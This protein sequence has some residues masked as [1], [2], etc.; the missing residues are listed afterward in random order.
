MKKIIALAAAVLL[1]LSVFSSMVPSSYAVDFTDGDYQYTVTD[2]EASITKYTGTALDLTVPSTLGGYPVVDIGGFSDAPCTRITIPDSVRTLGS[3]AFGPALEYLD[4]G[5][6]VTL[7]ETQCCMHCRNLREVVFSS[8]LVT[9]ESMAFSGVPLESVSFPASLETIGDSAFIE[10][11]D[12]TSVSFSEGLKSIGEGAFWLCSF[13][14]L[15]FPSTLE[16]IGE[17][18]FCFNDLLT[19]INFAGE[20]PICGEL[21]FSTVDGAR[22]IFIEQDDEA[23]DTF[24]RSVTPED[25]SPIDFVTNYQYAHM[26]SWTDNQT[27]L[28][29]WGPTATE[30]Y[31]LMHIPTATYI[32]DGVT[33]AT[34]GAYPG[35]AITN[36][37]AVPAKT[38]FTGEWNTDLTGVALN[39][40]CTVTAIYTY[41]GGPS[42][43]I[44]GLLTTLGAQAWTDSW[45][46]L[47]FAFT[48]DIDTMMNTM[49]TNDMFGFGFYVY[50]K[51]NMS[52]GDLLGEHVQGIKLY[53]S[54][55]GEY[56]PLMWVEGIDQYSNAEKM[57]ALRE[58]GCQIFSFDD[59]TFTIALVID[60]LGT[61][62]RQTANI[63]VRPF[64][65]INGQDVD[66]GSQLYNSIFNIKSYV[67]TGIGGSSVIWP[68]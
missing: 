48:I 32:A 25:F 68:N 33:V 3:G 22:R 34:R 20:K 43:D 63:V 55:S 62:E 37:P 18:A 38:N 65:E 58:A 11:L 41:V 44:P 12:L 59:N 52:D 35:Y 8:S 13:T 40:D 27:N 2:N 50:R 64:Y 46:K 23:L 53:A 60:N 31:R 49:Q 67:E 6:G 47:R 5:D 16:S 28:T 36:I 21:A 1:L 56:V 26:D 39:E 14:T 24:L 17:G 66:Y 45:D 54:E 9:I 29:D 57:D 19:E 51:D 42:P 61:A 10:C 4:M 7:I 30:R 15:S